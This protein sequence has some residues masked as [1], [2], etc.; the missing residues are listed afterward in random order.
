MMASSCKPDRLKMMSSY[1]RH[2]YCG[3]CCV[4]GK[5]QPHY[6]HFCALTGGEK[7]FIKEHA[8]SDTHDDCCICHAHHREVKR[9]QSDPKYIPTWKR[10]DQRSLYI[11]T[12]TFLE[13]HATSLIEKIIAPSDETQTTFRETLHTHHSVKLCNTDYQQL[14]RQTHIHHPCA[15]S[16][17]NLKAR[18]GANTR[19]SPDAAAIP[20]FARK[21]RLQC[22]TYIIRHTVH[23]VLH[24]ALSLL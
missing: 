3:P 12:R 6:N 4:C 23:I 8:S 14:Y 10:G 15:G 17:V 19:H 5:H 7:R 9:H 16:G 21:K 1:Y 22:R 20:L 24:H 11:T 13:C 18:Q 2:R